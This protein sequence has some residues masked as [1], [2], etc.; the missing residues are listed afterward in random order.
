MSF[1]KFITTAFVLGA[2]ATAALGQAGAADLPAKI[3]KKAPAE[4][5]FFLLVDNRVT[6]SWMPKGTDPG[7]FSVRPDG[8]I[9]GTTAQ[10][11]YSFTHFDIWQYGTNFFTIS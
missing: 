10:Q 1:R 3:A 9:K 4:L 5:P 6:F 11:G 2:G 8:S 7:V